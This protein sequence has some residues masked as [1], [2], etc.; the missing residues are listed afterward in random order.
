M[1][2]KGWAA[3]ETRAAWERARLL[4]EQV[5]A[6]REEPPLGLLPILVGFFWAN[7]SQFNGDACRDLAAQVLALVEKQRKSL[8]LTIGHCFTGMSLLL[9]GDIAE[10][11]AHFDRAI[12]LYDP[13]ERGPAG[14][15]FRLDYRVESLAFR[16]HVLWYLGFPE[17][18]L[19]DAEVALR[20]AREIDYAITLMSALNIAVW[21]HI[22]RRDY[23]TAKALLAELA[24]L[25]DE[26]GAAWFKAIGMLA[27]SLV[28]AM[29]KE[30]ADNVGMIASAWDA[31]LSTGATV[32]APMQRSYLAIAYAEIGQF[33]DARRCMGEAIAA[34]EKTKERWFEPEVHR[35]AGEIE[36]LSPERDMARAE[37]HFQRALEIARAQQAKSW[38]LR[39][40]TSLARLWRDQGRRAE[41][42]DLLAPV[43]DWFTEGFDTRDLKEAKALLEELAQ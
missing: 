30:G 36:L 6:L 16:S 24:S 15:M 11:R 9:S 12:E 35:I 13:A 5:E 3:P 20:D 19:A 42:R 17:A 23:A 7:F 33:D 34:T 1:W 38:E 28:S 14:T 2:A 39:T 21:T 43:Y 26:K 10:A 31:C 18:A 27:R 37:G 29:T 41:A 4:I 32:F 25:A 8:P 40:A 22:L